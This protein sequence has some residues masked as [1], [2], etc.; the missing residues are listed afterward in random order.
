MRDFIPCD[1]KVRES[2]DSFAQIRIIGAE[3]S[4]NPLHFLC[5][6]KARSR[7]LMT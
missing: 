6:L 2:T 1:E 5:R 4:G 3:G 7:Q